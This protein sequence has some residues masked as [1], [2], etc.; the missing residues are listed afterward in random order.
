MAIAAIGAAVGALISAY[1]AYSE[2]QARAKAFEYQQKVDE[3]RAKA[4]RDAAE[5]A[6]Q[7]QQ[8][9]AAHA[10]ARLRSMAAASGIVTGEGSELLAEME[11]AGNAK[12]DEKRIL[13]AGA[14][15]ASDYEQEGVLRGYEAK[16]AW[17]QG[18]LGAGTSLIGGA[19][20]AYSLYNSGG[21]S[22]GGGSSSYM[23][24]SDFYAEN[25]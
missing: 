2:G 7:T 19:A 14:I 12:L 10:K 4:A 5:A 9:E 23:A 22:G 18:Y 3:D 17:R 21:G 13:Y 11:S 25:R 1:A 24:G 6:A 20:R 15:R 16:G 8:E